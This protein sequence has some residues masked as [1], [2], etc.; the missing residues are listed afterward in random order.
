MPKATGDASE[1]I[2]LLKHEFS[3]SKMDPSVLASGSC[4]SD[5]CTYYTDTGAV[6]V[7][8]NRKH[9]VRVFYNI[10]FLGYDGINTHCDVSHYYF[11]DI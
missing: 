6:F 11:Y 10:Y 1:I 4:F 3:S 8:V 2:C 7:K 9:E 5:V